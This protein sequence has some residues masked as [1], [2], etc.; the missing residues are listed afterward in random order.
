M[1]SNDPN[2]GETVDLETANTASFSETSTNERG[3]ERVVSENST[4]ERGQERVVVSD[5]SS[6]NRIREASSSLGQLGSEITNWLA[7]RGQSES[8]SERETDRERENNGIIG[9]Y[10]GHRNT[11]T[12]LKEA[13]FW[14]D[15]YVLSGK[16]RAYL[17]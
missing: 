4:N 6:S 14:D 17:C 13:A 3:Q 15:K 11:R 8:E 7:E 9:R 5:D 1:I 16:T 12:I 10:T 2:S